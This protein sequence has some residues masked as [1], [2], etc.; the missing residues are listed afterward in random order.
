MMVIDLVEGYHAEGKRINGL[1]K[2]VG[3]N[4]RAS[5]VARDEV[6]A[7]F[8]LDGGEYGIAL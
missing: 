1:R 6:L 2:G 8:G 4:L 3:S 7:R 5:L